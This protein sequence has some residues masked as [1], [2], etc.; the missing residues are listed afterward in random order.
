[1]ADTRDTEV[2]RWN[3]VLAHG[4]EDQIEQARSEILDSIHTRIMDDDCHYVV[5]GW[6]PSF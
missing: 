5:A 3:A 4:T 6:T 1:M 2:A